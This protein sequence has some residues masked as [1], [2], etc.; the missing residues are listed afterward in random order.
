[1]IRPYYAGQYRR[2]PESAGARI[3]KFQVQGI[4]LLPGKDLVCDLVIPAAAGPG[5]VVELEI[6]AAD[7]VQ[8]PDHLLVAGHQIG[9]QFLFVGDRNTI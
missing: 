8:V 1:M 2:P 5:A 6:P 7:G 4:H 3:V 9:N